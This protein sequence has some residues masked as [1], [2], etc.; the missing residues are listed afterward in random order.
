VREAATVFVATEVAVSMKGSDP[1][2]LRDRTIFFQQ[3]TGY[4]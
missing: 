4:F 2:D 1:F 3:E